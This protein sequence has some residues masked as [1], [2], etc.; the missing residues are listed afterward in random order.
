MHASSIGFL[1]TAAA[2]SGC[3]ADIPRPPGEETASRAVERS[4]G[5]GRDLT[6]RA[7]ATP[8]LEVAS[9]AELSRPAPEPAP[10]ARR[11]PKPVRAPAPPLLPEVVPA[12]E[13]AAPVPAAAPAE[14]AVEEVP[15]G[16]VAVGVGR[17]LA[18]GKTV[19]VIPT[20]SGPSSA[21]AEPSWIPSAP[22]RGVIIEGGGGRGGKCRPRGGTRGIGIAGRI[23]HGVPGLRLR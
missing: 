16:D 19:T 22:A 23:P 12:A 18:P 11:S 5:A 20:S 21:P 9:P 13:L 1:L 15:E 6:L 7:T 14:V 8:T 2:L 4:T 3:A 17:E 10:R